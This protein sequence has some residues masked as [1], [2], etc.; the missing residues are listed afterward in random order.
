MNDPATLRALIDK[1]RSRVGPYFGDPEVHRR[2]GLAYFRGMQR[3]ADEL[4]AALSACA[5]AQEPEHHRCVGCGHRWHGPLK[6]AELCGDCWRKAQPVLHA[7]P[8]SKQEKPISGHP[9][10]CAVHA[11]YFCSCVYV[12][13]G[14]G[15]QAGAPAAP[16]APEGDTHGRMVKSSGVRAIPLAGRGAPP[17]GNAAGS[18]AVTD[19]TL[20]HCGN[21]GG[22]TFETV[23]V[24]DGGEEE[25]CLTCGESE[26]V[27]SSTQAT[28]A[29]AAA[30]SDYRPDHNGECLTCDEP[31]S[32]H[33]VAFECPDCGWD[34]GLRRYCEKHNPCFG[35]SQA[36]AAPAAPD[37]EEIVS[38]IQSAVD[39]HTGAIQLN[40]ATAQRIIDALSTRA[41]KQTP[42][43]PAPVTDDTLRALADRLDA[44]GLNPSMHELVS[45]LNDSA[46]A[47]RACADTQET[48]READALRAA[49][50]EARTALEAIYA[51]TRGDEHG[52]W[53]TIRK[54][55]DDRGIF[56]ADISTGKR[57]AAEVC[58]AAL[59]ARAWDLV[60]EYRT[61]T[62]ASVV[63]G[64]GDTTAAEDTYN[65]GRLIAEYDHTAAP[66]V[67]GGG[68]VGPR[69]PVYVGGSTIDPQK[70][71]SS[72]NAPLNTADED[73]F[74]V[75]GAWFHDHDREGC[76]PAVE[77]KG[78]GG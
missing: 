57:I 41:A 47:L 71:C 22:T 49:L 2:L 67:A 55:L 30:C 40:D 23:P 19:D 14:L 77:T 42:A 35:V 10:W 76:Y 6:G 33:E 70:V 43:A 25:R 74:L 78:G 31:A 12:P 37:I 13:K 59:A 21:C 1:W 48:R 53:W 28:A 3:C 17:A 29:P 24:V 39:C 64:T 44:L 56:N 26:R 68:G 8:A 60:Q 63:G 18:N 36:P 9:A 4:E 46:A 69:P 65:V 20:L 51:S 38:R 75:K 32:E 72:C 54:W 5:D 62:A 58:K 45:A 61:W 11:G 7:A 50:R 73:W 15:G 66:K 16:A 52:E 27:W 34:G